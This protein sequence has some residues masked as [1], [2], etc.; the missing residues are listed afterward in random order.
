VGAG[1]TWCLQPGQAL[2]HRQ[3]D[4]ECVLYNDLS[5]DTH[6]LDE[7]ALELLL[8]LRRGP[9]TRAALEAVLE[10]EFDID[11]AALA[12]DTEYLLQHLKRLYLVDSAA[13]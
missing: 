5:G 3:W 6:V 9:A 8:A 11:P 2:Q 7:P 12:D 10:K 4:G 13:C 1:T